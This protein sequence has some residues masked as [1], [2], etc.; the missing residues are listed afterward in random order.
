MAEE[1]K[2]T[3]EQQKQLEEQQTR[4]G[5]IFSQC[6]ESDE[7]KQAFIEDPKSIFAEYGVN[8]VN[9]LNYKIIDTPEKTIIHVLPYKGVK[10]GVHRFT[11]TLNKKVDDLKDDEEKQVLLEGWKY[12]IYQNTADTIYMPIPICPESLSPEELEMVNGGCI[13]FGFFFLVVAESVATATTV[14]ALAEI[15]AVAAE[16]FLAIAAQSVAA[17]TTAVVAWEVAGYTIG[18]GWGDEK[19]SNDSS[20]ADKRNRTR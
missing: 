13:I 6:W 19:S 2:L 16:V 11:D 5:E 14:F 17:V 1:I 4:L 8:Y 9:E 10:G 18:V 3:E 7:F 12:E 20:S 15:A